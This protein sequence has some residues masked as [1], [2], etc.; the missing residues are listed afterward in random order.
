[1]A[2][3]TDKNSQEQEPGESNLDVIKEDIYE[4]DYRE[5]AISFLVKLAKIVV[6]VFLV[7]LTLMLSVTY[8]WSIYQNYFKVPENVQVPDLV[9]KDLAVA[10]DLLK[11][12]GLQIQVEESRYQ[13]DVPDRIVIE[14]NPLSGREAR[15]NRTVFVTVSLGPELIVVP[16]FEGM[17]VREVELKL[18]EVKLRMGKVEYK[19]AVWG[20]PERVLSQKPEPEARIPKGEFVQLTVQRGS[21]QVMMDMPE[22]RGYTLQ[23]AKRSL[24]KA[25]L[26]IEEIEWVTHARYPEGR[27]V[28]QSIEPEV[29]VP[30]GQKVKLAV[31]MGNT[32]RKSFFKQKMITVVAPK[33]TRQHQVDV[34][35]SNNSGTYPVFQGTMPSG[36]DPLNVA[37][38]GLQGSDIEVYFDKILSRRERL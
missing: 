3:R 27:V 5:V 34:L 1:M 20:E 24:A 4:E 9:G 12:I 16:N 29:S 37:V 10:H 30:S 14:Q 28:A 19:E 38:T 23:A 18:S 22:C 11:D 33:G 35:L 31:S 32:Q 26:D 36:S 2:N 8:G 7:G 25:S 21:K 15:K 17:T 6:L 13:K